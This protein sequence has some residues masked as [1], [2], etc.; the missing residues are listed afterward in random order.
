MDPRL[1]LLNLL[2]RLTVKRKLKRL[3]D[4]LVLRALMERDASRLVPT[5]DAH[6]VDDLMRRP[7]E[8]RKVGMIE[9]LWASCGRPDRRKVALHLHGGAYLAGSPRTHKHLGAA[10]AGAAGV[11]VV[12]PHYRRAPEHPFPAALDDALAAYRHLLAAGYT[13]EEIAVGGDSAGGGLA[14]A[15][16]LKLQAEGDPQPACLYGLSPWADLTGQ[17]PSIRRN[18]TRDAMLPAGRMPE[19]A[20]MYLSGHD[21]ADP[22]ASP[23]FGT[24]T[25]PPP[26]LLMASKR[27]ILMD[28]ALRLA[29]RLRD[30]GGDVQLELWRGVPHAWPIFRGRIAQADKAVAKVG[31]FIAH[32]LKAEPG[33]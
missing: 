2:L 13:P 21:E 24:W 19:V 33:I 12:L 26:S 7:G 9:A 20:A 18:A 22:L 31:S 5:P 4:P 15:L 1:F 14:F 25:T 17:A 30:A 3:E 10:I 11:R 6:F 29:E 16:S 23:A 8:P 28:D 32:H 27:E